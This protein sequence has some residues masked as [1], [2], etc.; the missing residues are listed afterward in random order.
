MQDFHIGTVAVDEDKYKGGES[1]YVRAG[2]KTGGYV[3]ASKRIYSGEV[4][5]WNKSP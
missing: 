1:R 3:S 2:E 4:P 5:H